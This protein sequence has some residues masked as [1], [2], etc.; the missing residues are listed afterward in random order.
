M[1]GWVQVASYPCCRLLKKSYEP[2]RGQLFGSP[3]TGA[4]VWTLL[5]QDIDYLRPIFAGDMYIH[6]GDVHSANWR[7]GEQDGDEEGIV[8]TEGGIRWRLAHPQV[9]TSL[10]FSFLP[11]HPPGIYTHT[12]HA[13]TYACTCIR[14]L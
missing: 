7:E 4:A 14:H 6:R 1:E 5:E 2:S 8:V 9:W 11:S 13:C 3:W 10:F 12:L